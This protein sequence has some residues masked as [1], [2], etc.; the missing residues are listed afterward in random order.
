MRARLCVTAAVPGVLSNAT[1]TGLPAPP[2]PAI[3]S[4]MDTKP[5][6][7]L[8]R[9]GPGGGRARDSRKPSSKPTRLACE[10]WNERILGFQG[11]A[12]RSPTLGDAINAGYRYLE[13]KC[14]GGDTH[15]A[16]PSTWCGVTEGDAG[17][18][19]QTLHALPPVFRSAGLSLQTQLFG[20]AAARKDFRRRSAVAGRAVMRGELPAHL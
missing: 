16:V 7:D 13:V 4:R 6:D 19:T 12:R 14:I 2:R 18:R 10:A 15:Q 11:P 8:R 3:I 17:P 5:R 1:R 20:R 9:I